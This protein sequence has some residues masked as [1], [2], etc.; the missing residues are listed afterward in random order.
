[1]EV[2]RLGSILDAARA[3]RIRPRASRG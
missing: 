1:V 2:D 3:H